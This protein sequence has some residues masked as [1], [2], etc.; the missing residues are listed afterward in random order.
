MKNGVL[1]NGEATFAMILSKTTSLLAGFIQKESDAY[2]P[3]P[4]N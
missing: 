1:I 4:N 3:M 2:K